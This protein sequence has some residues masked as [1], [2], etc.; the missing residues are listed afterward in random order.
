MAGEDERLRAERA[1]FGEN[2]RAAREACGMGQR[3]LARL[4]SERGRRWHQN[5]VSKTEAGGRTPNAFE[6]AELAAVLGVQTDR[7]FW[8]PPE[9]NAIAD[10]GEAAARLSDAYAG[11][12]KAVAALHTARARARSA[13]SGRRDSK[14]RQVRNVCEAL[15]DSLASAT[16]EAALAEG[17][18]WLERERKA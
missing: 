5:T 4:M 15:D 3:E 6:L 7:F 11:A 8:L 1:R 16:P 18:A 10:V 13:L 14:F 17:A 12:V 9:A 2:L